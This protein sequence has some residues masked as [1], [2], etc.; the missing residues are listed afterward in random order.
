MGFDEVF[1]S[2][3]SHLYEGGQEDGGDGEDEEEADD[4]DRKADARMQLLEESQGSEESQE[5]EPQDQLAEEIGG[6]E[7]EGHSTRRV[8]KD[9]VSAV[10]FKVPLPGQ[11]AD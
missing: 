7:G 2:M 1:G 11:F 5:R 8:G 10:G 6:T 3:A 4:G 9:D